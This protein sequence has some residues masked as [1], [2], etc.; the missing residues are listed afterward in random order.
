MREVLRRQLDAVHYCSGPVQVG[1]RVRVKIDPA[2]RKDHMLMHTGQHV[3]LCPGS[4]GLMLTVTLPLQKLVSAILEHEFGLDTVAWAL[5]PHPEPSY[6]ELPRAPTLEELQRVQ[7][8]C[9]EEIAANRNITVEVAPLAKEQRPE[10]MPA[11]YQSSGSTNGVVRVVDIHGLDR[12][13]SVLL[14]HRRLGDKH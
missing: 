9:N 14:S 10:S 6:I 12:N 4:H 8:R 1:K 2:R 13:P 3:R 11:D 5:T 7:D